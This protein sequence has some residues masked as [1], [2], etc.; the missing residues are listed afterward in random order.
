MRKP[1]ALTPVAKRFA[2]VA[3]KSLVEE[4]GN[5]VTIEFIKQDGTPRVMTGVVEDIKGGG[6]KEVV[7]MKTADGYRSAN[8][9]RI[10]KKVRV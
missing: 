3:R 10:T 6:D 1:E 4:V 7:I 8:L 5:T 9:S 2:T